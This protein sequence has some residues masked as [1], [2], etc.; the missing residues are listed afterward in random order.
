MSYIEGNL[1]SGEKIIY[2][3]YI[4]RITYLKPLLCAIAGG[5]F[6]YLSP[7]L[8]EGSDVYSLYLGPALLGLG[9]I[10]LCKKNIDRTHSEFV[11]T[12][13]R[14][15]HKTG[16]LQLKTEEIQLASF[17]GANVEQ[18]MIGMSINSGTVKVMGTG[19][20]VSIFKDIADPV[21]FRNQIQSMS[22]Q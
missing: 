17:E 15:L 16:W 6:I 9:F 19:G 4:H 1:M 5:L 22:A 20:R 12:N 14:V 8:G 13:K 3:A 7:N 2:R 11:V 18:G 10:V 21:E